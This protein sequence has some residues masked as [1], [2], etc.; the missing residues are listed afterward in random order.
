MNPKSNTLFHFTKNA[1]SLKG[2][3]KN[4]FLPRYCREDI[5]YLKNAEAS[6]DCLGYPMV[7][8]CDIPLSRISEHTKFY[9]SYG[10]GM[11]KEWGIKNALAPILYTPEE[12]V[13]PD[14][15]NFL[16]GFDMVDN[17]TAGK[18]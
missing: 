1:K 7:C 4:G 2:I 12:G 18:I 8:F 17:N 16:L 9:G 11:T 3:L 5:K 14:F 13:F 10:L 6:K 15:A